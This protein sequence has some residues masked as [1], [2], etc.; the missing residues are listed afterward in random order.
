MVC[1]L[2]ALGFNKLLEIIRERD[3]ACDHVGLDLEPKG[4]ELVDLT[5]GW[6][7]CL[8]HRAPVAVVHPC[9][10]WESFRDEHEWITLG[11]ISVSRD[12]GL[13]LGGDFPCGLKELH[14]FWPR[15]E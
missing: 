10:D 1:E 14:A 6:G 4:P 8:V 12:E 2:G 15:A 11:S 9:W 3:N 7:D 5:E 13:D